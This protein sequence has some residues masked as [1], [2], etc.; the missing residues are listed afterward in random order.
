MHPTEPPTRPDAI[1]GR[2]QSVQVDT[3]VGSAH[4]HHRPISY[5]VGIAAPESAALAWRTPQPDIDLRRL[6]L[7]ELRIL[8]V[9]SKTGSIGKA[10]AQLTQLQPAVSKASFEDAHSQ[11]AHEHA[12]A[13]AAHPTPT[14]GA[15][16]RGPVRKASASTSGAT[17]QKT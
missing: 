13:G 2:H 3:F 7:R 15:P 12:W 17:N 6:K 5:R 8:M 16:R 9:V 1:G 4:F 11:C 14:L 10:T